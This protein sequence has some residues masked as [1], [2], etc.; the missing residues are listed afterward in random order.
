LARAGSKTAINSAII[1]IT[2]NSSTSVNPASLPSSLKLRRT[3]R[4]A[5]T[6][7][8][9]PFLELVRFFMIIPFSYTALFIE[10]LVP[11]SILTAFLHRLL[12]GT[13]TF[14]LRKQQQISVLILKFTPSPLFIGRNRTLPA[15]RRLAS[16]TGGGRIYTNS[17]GREKAQKTQ[18]VNWLLVLLLLSFLFIFV[19][20]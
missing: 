17:Y 10:G 15:E 5:V 1:E 18:K 9:N 20:I 6:S 16:L 19:A 7:P 3:G 12:G 4:F 8:L 13:I 14:I 11:S 2:T